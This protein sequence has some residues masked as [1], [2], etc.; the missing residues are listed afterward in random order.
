MSKFLKG[1]GIKVQSGEQWGISL[2]GTLKMFLGIREILRILLYFNAKRDLHKI[3][4]IHI[5]KSTV[6]PNILAGRGLSCFVSFI[7]NSK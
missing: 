2:K 7:Q 4:S 5:H 3:A 6:N 1:L